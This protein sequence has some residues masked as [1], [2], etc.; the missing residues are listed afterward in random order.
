[1]LYL[2][3]ALA[4]SAGVTLY[5]MKKGKIEDS[6][7]DLIPDVVEEKVA[8]VKLRA[9]RIKEE[10]ADV[11]EEVKDVVEQAKD[12]P[13]AVQ[14]K[15]RRGRKPAAKKTQSAKPA[16]KKPAEKKA[17]AKKSTGTRKRAAKKPA[18]SGE[19]SAT[20]KKK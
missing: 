18:T 5:L 8:D 11:V 12:I 6:D 17:P 13:A 9:K 4:L 3:L 19:G 7:G 14:N 15:P 1:M 16:E 20:L 2:L 10:V